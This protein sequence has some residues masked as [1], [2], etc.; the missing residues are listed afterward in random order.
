LGLSEAGA[1]TNLFENL[2]VNSVGILQIFYSRAVLQRIDVD[3]P[4][5]FGDRLDGKDGS[6]CTYNPSADEIGRLKGIL[7]LLVQSF[8]L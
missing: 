4:A 8:E 3:S 7:Y 1:R 6:L 5:F 2:S